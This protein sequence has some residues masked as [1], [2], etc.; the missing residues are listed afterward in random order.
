MTNPSEVDERKK[1]MADATKKKQKFKAIV[2]GGGGPVGMYLAHALQATGLDHVVCEKRAAI[3]RAA[4]FGLFLWPHGLR[5]LHQAGLLDRTEAISS[6]LAKIT[7]TGRRARWCAST[8][9]SDSFIWRIKS[10]QRVNNSD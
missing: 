1:E 4:A 10:L 2:I 6:L 7:H 9:T 3:P 5:L 8:A